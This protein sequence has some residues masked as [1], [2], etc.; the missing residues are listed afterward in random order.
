LIAFFL[1]MKKYKLDEK[2][3]DRIVREIEKTE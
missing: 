3:Y 2:E 1:V